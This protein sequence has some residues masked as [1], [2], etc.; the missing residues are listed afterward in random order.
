[1]SGRWRYNAG[2]IGRTIQVLSALC[3]GVLT[4]ISVAWWFAWHETQLAMPY[5]IEPPGARIVVPLPPGAASEPFVGGVVSIEAASFPGT[6]L[7]SISRHQAHWLRPEFVPRGDLRLP[8]WIGRLALPWE[9]NATWEP[10]LLHDGTILT[11]GWPVPTMWS[12]VR[13]TGSKAVFERGA[14]Y[15]EGWLAKLGPRG[16]LVILPMASSYDVAFPLRPIW[17]AFVLS[18]GVWSAVWWLLIVVPK[19][20]RRRWRLRRHRCTNCGY[21]RAGLPPGSACPECGHPSG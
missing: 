15:F 12:N 6:K 21:L 13:T 14:F 8:A 16:P 20:I 10:S 11:R 1:M 4:T 17:P 18:S 3:L 7:W 2:V 9:H 19:W 5:L